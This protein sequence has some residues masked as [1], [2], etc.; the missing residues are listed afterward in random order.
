[1]NYTLFRKFYLI[2][3]LL[4]ASQYI[5]AERVKIPAGEWA[6]HL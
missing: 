4:T 5:Y 3:F 6:Q 2:I 1:M